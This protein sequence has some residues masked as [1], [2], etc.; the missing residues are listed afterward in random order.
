MFSSESEGESESEEAMQ[1]KLKIPRQG[2]LR[3]TVA[4]QDV[5]VK[6]KCDGEFLVRCS[7]R[8]L[9]YPPRC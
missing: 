6:I 8:V 9:H 5:R 4:E 7:L 3:S 1:M 2:L